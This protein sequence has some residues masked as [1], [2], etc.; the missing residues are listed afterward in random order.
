ML[1][2]ISCLNCGATLIV[3]SNSTVAQCE[4]CKS[5][6]DVFHALEATKVEVSRLSEVTQLK[7]RLYKAVDVN[8]INEILRITQRLL[9]WIPNDFESNYFF[10]FAKDTVNQ[11]QYLYDFLKWNQPISDQSKNVVHKH[12]F[13]RSDIRHRELV[14]AYLQ[15]HAPEEVPL[16]LST[17]E[18]RLIMEEQY[19]P[20]PKDLFICHSSNDLELVQSIVKLIE[21]DGFTC[22]VSYRNLRPSD[23]ENYWDNITKAIER[24]QGFLLISSSSAYLSK[25]VQREVQLAQELSKRR[26]EIRL[27][28]TPQTTLIKYVFDGIKWIQLENGDLSSIKD[29]LLKRIYETTHQKEEHHSLSLENTYPIIDTKPSL[30]IPRKTLLVISIALI[31]AFSL[32]WLLNPLNHMENFPLE[33][34]GIDI[35]SVDAESQAIDE[36]PPHLFINSSEPLRHTI[37]TEFIDRAIR[38]RDE[39]DNSPSVDFFGL[40]ELTSIGTY[41]LRYQAIDASGNRSFFITREVHVV[42]KQQYVLISD[43]TLDLVQR[44]VDAIFFE[45]GSIIMIAAKD[46]DYYLLRLNAAYDL[47]WFV[48]LPELKGD[49]PFPT[50][51]LVP[52]QNVVVLQYV[53][54]ESMDFPTGIHFEAFSIEG[55]PLA[56]TYFDYSSLIG[57]HQFVVA[58][59]FVV[60]DDAIFFGIYTLNPISSVQYVVVLEATDLSI[61]TIDSITSPA[62]EITNPIMK[63]LSSNQSKIYEIGTRALRPTTDANQILNEQWLYQS[64]YNADGSFLSTVDFR[65]QEGFVNSFDIDAFEIINAFVVPK[66]TSTIFYGNA[67]LT[68]LDMI[69]LIGNVLDLNTDTNGFRNPKIHQ[70]IRAITNSVIDWEIVLDPGVLFTNNHILSEVVAVNYAYYHPDLNRIIVSIEHGFSQ[71]GLTTGR[72]LALLII[73]PEGLIESQLI[74][75]KPTNWVR[76]S[77]TQSTY[78]SSGKVAHVVGSF[79]I[80]EETMVED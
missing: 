66:D 25:D 30:A 69:V 8:D 52:D 23:S 50:L 45:D 73:T 51:G 43:V 64:I 54:H 7:Q 14:I 28:H 38:V 10:A 2:Q 22:W 49:Y 41:N 57:T 9:E 15:V 6:V 4:Y 32:W 79:I 55:E 39:V 13:A 18:Q 62:N 68:T 20:V 31:G 36:N 29:V 61:R 12:L 21:A 24:S 48:S 3:T 17:I 19:L 71:T 16:Y 74:I 59:E 78:L 63:L 53:T 46:N 33:Q 11:P 35:N 1:K 37:N 80:I 27:D 5:T 60:I 67:Q 42:P 76:G 34:N 72:N 75:D 26:F 77:H 40:E 70:S 65:Q 44:I 58:N 47:D 56:K